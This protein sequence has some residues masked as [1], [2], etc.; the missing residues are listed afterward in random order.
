MAFVFFPDLP[1]VF[2]C[3]LKETRSGGHIVQ[4]GP[5]Q[6]GLSFLG[7]YPVLA[8]LELGYVLTANERLQERI[9]WLVQL[10][11]DVTGILTTKD[12]ARRRH[13]RTLGLMCTPRHW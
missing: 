1:Q 13:A 9:P 3:C 7:P 2:G 12:R 8:A 6:N 5:E 11:R 10:K 4:I